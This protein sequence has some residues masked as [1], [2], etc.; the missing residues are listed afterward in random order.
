MAVV[1][2]NPH[3]EILK[4]IIPK[5]QLE[6][7]ITLEEKRDDSIKVKTTK[8]RNKIKNKSEDE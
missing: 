6:K 3:Q 4:F 8:Q 1:I 7:E 5:E 2:T